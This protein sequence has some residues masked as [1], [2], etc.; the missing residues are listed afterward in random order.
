MF[1]DD[2][3]GTGSVI[4]GG[5]QNAARIASAASGGGAL[6]DHRIL[7]YGSG[8][9]GVG[10]A[11]QVMSFFINLGMTE[12]E[13]KARI[14][15][16]DSKGLIFEGRSGGLAK[17][18]QYF[19]RADYN[20][21]PIKNLEEI[22]KYVRPT[23]LLGLSTQKNAFTENVVSLM[24]S[25]NP[26]PIIFPLSNPS[27]LCELEFADAIRWSK[28]TALFASG[29]P[30][31]PIQWEGEGYE[32]GQGNNMYVFPGIG[33]GVIISGATRITDK[34]IEHSGIALAESMT[35]EERQAGLL[36]PRLPRIREISASIAVGV[37][38]QAQAEDVDEIKKLRD[39]SDRELLEHVQSQMWTPNSP[40]Q[41][42]KGKL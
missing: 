8:S 35:E 17:H 30:Y 26:R 1:N 9:A 23:A 40:S 25:L 37:I 32:P 41:P 5:F 6:K 3:Q 10:V 33:L 11:K 16:V 31:L 4:L 27:S 29:S 22:I 38:R 42:L 13:A 28:G 34:M 19:A 21:P 15:T 2:I 24:A 18:K 20:G 14:W 39:L 7:F 12:E 36:Y